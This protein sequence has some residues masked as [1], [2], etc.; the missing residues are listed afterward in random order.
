MYLKQNLRDDTKLLN[1]PLEIV[2]EVNGEKCSTKL[3]LT[4][5]AAL[6]IEVPG[7]MLMNKKIFFSFHVHFSCE[8]G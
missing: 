5:M 3:P 1:F 7:Q 4:S 2:I 8:G 6:N